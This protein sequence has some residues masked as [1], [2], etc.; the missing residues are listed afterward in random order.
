MRALFWL[1]LLFA[2]A[3]TLALLTGNNQVMLT[4]YWPP[5]TAIDFSL[6]FAL[7]ALISVFAIILV[8]M[9]SASALR[10]LPQKARRW[11]ILQRERAMH[12]HMLD[13]LSHYLAGRFARARKSA[14]QALQHE[15]ELYDTA[16]EHAEPADTPLPYRQQLRT[17]AYFIIAQSSHSL[18]DVPARDQAL[19][20][21]QQEA[22]T[23]RGET[24]QETRDGLHLRAASWLLDDHAPLQA[25]QQLSALP[26]GAS[27]RIQ[28]LRIKLKATRKL[29][30]TKLALETGRTLV[31][32]KAFSEG[33]GKVLMARLASDMIASANDPQ[34]L[35]TIWKKLDKAERAQ[36]E[37]ALQAA[38]RMI[39]LQGNIEQ[40]RIWLLPVWE[41]FAKQPEDLPQKQR[42]QLISALQNSADVIDNNWLQRIEA[43]H[44]RMPHYADLQYLMGMVC[45]QRQLWGKAQQLLTQSTKG[46]QDDPTLLRNAWRALA[47]IAE[48][49]QDSEQATAAWKQ[50][51]LVD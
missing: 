7:A 49:R 41:R 37:V 24:A 42:S 4:M 5:N 22:K 43:A 29:G 9:R 34:Q 20:V 19:Q 15:A 6:N 45:L 44:L 12:T 26:Q 3:V 35:E 32:H 11:R 31:R 51:A 33:A 2:L 13:A 27:R 25:L 48:S 10:K 47:L 23:I 17:Q 40:A 16:C 14:Q 1:L 8:L 18:Q 21:A 36:P 38:L 39:E 30:Q 28:A 46:L 50:A